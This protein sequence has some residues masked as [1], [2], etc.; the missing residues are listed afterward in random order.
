MK[1]D[2]SGWTFIP[3]SGGSYGVTFLPHSRYSRV[4]WMLIRTCF[5]S[6]PLVMA[7]EGPPA[8]H[9]KARA[10]PEES[11]SFLCLSILPID[12]NLISP[13]HLTPTP[14]GP[15]H[16]YMVPTSLFCLR[17]FFRPVVSY[18]LHYKSS[19]HSKNFNLTL[20]NNMLIYSFHLCLRLNF[21][22]Y[23]LT[24]TKGSL[25]KTNSV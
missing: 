12:W 19:S 18:F 10:P 21:Y 5:F 1:R 24:T 16:L 4:S 2:C 15:P 9:P 25:K 3:Y 17:G 23:V 7:L 6:L 20:Y 14:N 22:L 8:R 11:V 13:I